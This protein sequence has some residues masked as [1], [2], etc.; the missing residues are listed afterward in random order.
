MIRL[1][2]ITVVCMFALNVA[3]IGGGAWYLLSGRA[4]PVEP[5]PTVAPLTPIA[6]TAGVSLCHELAGSFQAAGE[7]SAQHDGSRSWAEALKQSNLA[8]VRRALDPVSAAI[9]QQLGIDPTD[10]AKDRWDPATARRIAGEIAEGL[11]S[12][13]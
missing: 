7:A 13:E 5:E 6:R 3:A 4:A 12:V 8:A 9:G 10:P 1:L 11:L 2:T